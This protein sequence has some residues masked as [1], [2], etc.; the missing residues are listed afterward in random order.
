[1]KKSLF[2]WILLGALLS[3]SSM[4]AF[5]A[6]ADKDSSS[7]ASSASALPSA[8]T[9]VQPADPAVERVDN[10]SV[11]VAGAGG[12]CLNL[13]FRQGAFG[14]CSVSPNKC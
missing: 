6:N 1:M 5:A 2:A 12:W 8:E 4:P 7:R 11:G 9:A 14:C 13:C 10:R 3:V